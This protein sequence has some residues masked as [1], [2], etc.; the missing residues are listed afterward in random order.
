MKKKKKQ[1]KTTLLLIYFLYCWGCAAWICILASGIKYCCIS[2]KLFFFFFI[3][4][5]INNLPI[6]LLYGM[7]VDLLTKMFNYLQNSRVKLLD[8]T[9]GWKEKIVISK[10][11]LCHWS[12]SVDMTAGS[13]LSSQTCVEKIYTSFICYKKGCKHVKV[14]RLI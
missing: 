7:A 2:I 12:H 13:D 3:T 6:V 1:K 8:T 11:F 10:N 9:Q 14:A 4:N 5:K